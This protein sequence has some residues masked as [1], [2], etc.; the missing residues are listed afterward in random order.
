[1]VEDIFD[2][3]TECAVNERMDD[4]ML[5]NQDYMEIQIKIEEQMR[6]L[7]ELNLNKEQSLIV[8]RLISSHNE[9][10]SLYGRMTYKQGFKDCISLL[11]E[12]NLIRAS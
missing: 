6:Q 9:S 10:G 2:I 3:V 7:D 1:M 4:I 11:Q 5:Q 8:D 12:I